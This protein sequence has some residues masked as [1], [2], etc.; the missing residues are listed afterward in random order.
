MHFRRVRHAVIFC[1]L[2]VHKSTPVAKTCFAISEG[3]QLSSAH[4]WPGGASDLISLDLLD[5]PKHRLGRA[6]ERLRESGDG[7]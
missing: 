5:D 2:R 6:E 7:A 3:N 4:A 1:R